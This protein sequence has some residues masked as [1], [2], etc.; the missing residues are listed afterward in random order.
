MKKSSLQI[1]AVVTVLAIAGILLI[2]TANA[3]WVKEM[4]V[5]ME[6]DNYETSD[7]EITISRVE[8][9]KA[10]INFRAII[11]CQSHLD[12]I[13]I[14]EKR[15]IFLIFSSDSPG[16]FTNGDA[17]EI[18]KSFVITPEETTEHYDV[19]F[20]SP[21]KDN[22]GTNQT[23]QELLEYWQSL[24][25]KIS[26]VIIDIIRS[27]TV[28]INGSGDLMAVR[29]IIVRTEEPW[30]NIDWTIRNDRLEI[31]GT[32]N[33]PKDTIVEWRF[34]SPSISTEGDTKVDRNRNIRFAINNVDTQ[35]IR[36]NLILEKDG[37]LIAEEKIIWPIIW[38]KYKKIVTPIPTTEKFNGLPVSTSYSPEIQEI[39]ESIPMPTMPPPTTIKGMPDTSETPGMTWLATLIAMIAARTIIKRKK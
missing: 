26:E 8:G 36:A 25:N 2:S 31:Y 15:D 1:L 39:S 28:G 16:D 29:K 14:D 19:I 22:Y 9:E 23:I 32:T 27:N 5:E 11:D 7:K 10:R 24:K 20:L 30:I 6:I 37:K 3:H 12:I 33:L 34:V 17:C 18:R 13:E 4:K 38:P 35:T 21:G